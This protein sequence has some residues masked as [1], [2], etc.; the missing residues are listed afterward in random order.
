M[1]KTV[2]NQPYAWILGIDVSKES[3]DVCLIR[4]GD[5]QIFENKF[6]NNVSGFKHLK[7]WCKQFH[8]ECDSHTLC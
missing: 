1:E 2:E 8:C 6:H 4:Q 3:I 7:T 5:G